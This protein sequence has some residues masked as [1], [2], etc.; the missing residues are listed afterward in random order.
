MADIIGNLR[1]LYRR[2]F[3]RIGIDIILII[4]IP[5][6]FILVAL[7]YNLRENIRDVTLS[8]IEDRLKN[9]ADTALGNLDFIE[10][11]LSFVAKHLEQHF[12]GLGGRVKGVANGVPPPNWYKAAKYKNFMDDLETMLLMNNGFLKVRVI[13]N[14]GREIV[15][16]DRTQS[17]I[18][19]VPFGELEDKSGRDYFK[20]AMS[21]PAG[22]VYLHPITLDVEH[23]EIL[24]PHTPVIRLCRKLLLTGGETLGIL[25]L[26]VSPDVIFGAENRGDESGTMIID[27]AGNYLR[28]R[29]QRLL[30]GGEND[31]KANLLNERP[32]MKANMDKYDRMT[33]F[34]A[35]MGEYRVWRK[36]FYRDDDRSHFW[37]FVEGHPEFSI[38]RG[39]TGI[40]AKSAVI[41]VLV[42]LA[43][44]SLVVAVIYRSLRPMRDVTA[45]IRKLEAGD[46]STRVPS[47]AKNEIGEIAVAFNSLAERLNQTALELQ[48]SMA[49]AKSI[50]D[51][52]PTAHIIASS[53]GIIISVNPAAAEMFGYTYREML[54]QSVKM[55][56]PSVKDDEYS[57]YIKDYFN[58]KKSGL[59]EKRTTIR[60]PKEM[61]AIRKNGEFFY[62][63]LYIREARVDGEE[64]FA[65]IIE[66]ITERREAKI[67]LTQAVENSDAIM[68]AS[69]ETLALIGLEGN[70]IAI[71][72]AGAKRL[73]AHRADLI[74][75]SLYQILPLELAMNRM[76]RFEEVAATGRS[77]TFEDERN[78]KFLANSIYPVIDKDGLVTRCALFAVDVTER[79]QWE[80]ALAEREAKMRAI[81]VSVPDAIILID[82]KGTVEMLNPAGAR[83]F[84][85]AA[86]DVIDQNIK[87]LM[88]EP[89]QSGHD[90]YLENYLHTGEK[91]I[92][93]NLRE[94]P[95]LRKDGSRFPAELYVTELWLGQT[96]KFLGIVRDIS[97]RK[98]AE[99]ALKKSGE[100]L[101][102]SYLKY[103][104]IMD[105]VASVIYTLSLEGELTFINKEAEMIMGD[106]VNECLKK[107]SLWE[108]IVVKE[109][110]GEYLEFRSNVLS[111]SETQKL[112]Y[113]I[114]CRDGSVVWLE[115]RCS[116]I[117]D[118]DGKVIYYQGIVDD[119]TE[120]KKLEQVRDNFFHAVVHDLKSPMTGIK[121]EL[122]MLDDQITSFSA[123]C[124]AKEA[125]LNT[126]SVYETSLKQKIA[127]IG[128][129]IDQL[130]LMIQSLLKLGEIDEEKLELHYEAFA[131]NDLLRELERDFRGRV[132]AK[133]LS[134]EFRNSFAGTVIADFK[135]LKRVLQNLID[136]AVKYSLANTAITIDAGCSKKQ[137][138]S[139]NII[140][141]VTNT[142]QPLTE[143]KINALFQ[144]FKTLGHEE[145]GSGIGLFFCYKTME[146]LGGGI[147]VDQDMDTITFHIFFP[148]G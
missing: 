118:Y 135:L 130:H 104:A 30:L 24:I 79:K 84:G 76:K 49:L 10:D 67:A 9:K 23:G 36:V 5:A 80:R 101:R 121:L 116:A 20:N 75:K 19:E 52:A 42:I 120:I 48:R 56:T 16:F 147:Y 8:R 57:K 88:P 73:N 63:T 72:E 12:F 59:P 142:G 66:D 136:N 133:G 141:S 17:G 126:I 4:I 145:S 44:F 110:V 134:I 105:H 132:S 71:N 40:L 83:I 22:K 74:G 114:K 28:H 34:D 61:L 32:L 45:A 97:E 113:R 109:D 81:L 123:E 69:N 102:E 125:S 37:V 96:R 95:G 53:G 46:M 31:G 33:I 18:K 85:W 77:L 62:V 92:I 128:E 127:D 2:L 91:K 39:Y 50:S 1:C 98:L 14:S 82:E 140:I 99:E 103:S 131:M 137:G 108:D 106:C 3:F 58:F 54:G 119:I 43:G 144:K 68:N 78:G 129:G 55:F 64:V 13:N 27:E 89:Y 139:E 111:S 100:S 25:V 41:L 90:R 60:T 86:E 65:G 94:V 29:D 112:Q 51:I 26:T 148:N 38:I 7:A 124:A 122:D 47:D 107:H 21:Y 146:L 70:V 143:N 117:N 11:D 35:G 6:A 93:G 138:G 115:D 15:R 87:I